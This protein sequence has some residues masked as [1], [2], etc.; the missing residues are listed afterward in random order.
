[1]PSNGRPS[2]TKRNREQARRERN[3]EKRS[4]ATSAPSRSAIARRPQTEKIRTSRES[5][6][7]LSLHLGKIEDPRRAPT[8]EAGRAEARLVTTAAASATAA[9]VPAAIST[10]TPP[11]T[12]AA[13][14]GALLRL[15]DLE[16]VA[17]EL[18]TVPLGHRCLRV[19]GARHLDEGEAAGLAGIAVG[20]DLHL[21]HFASALL[22]GGAQ[23]ALAWC[24]TT[25]YL[26]KA[27]SQLPS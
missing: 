25:D 19:R 18:L 23:R 10:T 12:A 16:R 15:V 27:G 1:M 11:T 5:S 9:A 13:A 2:L 17:V 22:E 20:D 4:G 14:T 7:V 24:R 8:S 6:R 26:R 3:Q 21:R